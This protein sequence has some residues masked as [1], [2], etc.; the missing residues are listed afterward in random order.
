[1]PLSSDPEPAVR[2]EAAAPS[3]RAAFSLSDQEWRA[4]VDKTD[5][6]WQEIRET[7]CLP[8]RKLGALTNCRL[9]LKYENLQYIG[10]FKERGALAKL[11]SLSD[12]ERQSGVV[13]ASAGNHAQG[14]ARHAELL[15][16]RA[17]IVMPAQTP[18]VKV[19]ETKRFGAEVIL[20]GTDFEAAH[21]EAI[22]QVEEE[23]KTLVH[24]FDDPYVAAGQGT[25][26]KEMLCEAPEIDTLV[27]PIGGGGLIAGM[28]AVAK[29][30]RP[31]IRII[32]VQAALY[33]GMANAVRNES[34]P[35]GGMTLAEG[36]A[37]CDPGRFT[38]EVVARLVDEI[39]TVDE[40]ALERS[41]SLL[42]MT[43]K[44]L[45]EGAGAAGLAA[46]LAHPHLFE[47]H[48][49]GTI[50]CG[51]NI[52]PR[53]L[54]SILMRDLARQRR[55]A[56]LRVPLM[57][58]PGQLTRVSA[59]IGAAGGNVIDVSYHKVFNDLPAKQTHLDISV[60]ATGPAHMDRIV[61]ALRAEGLEP[62][63]ANY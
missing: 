16:I 60:E 30:M 12:A 59:A 1:M 5:P 29:E 26:A 45:A 54:S 20:H 40:R 6:A 27:I 44:T 48:A 62:E 15:G 42:L 56:R 46:L 11:L 52:D 47:G 17:T 41:L 33:P 21:A 51:G 13:A 32:G 10:A 57:D 43:Q 38:R 55:L 8:S 24:P 22:R 61:E 63:V 37:V 23:G 49:V 14:L 19:E 58:V 31:D 4:I 39:V 34:A 9:W 2:G 3:P 36:I 18:S 28:A 25:I 53:L 7:P 35:C 50:V